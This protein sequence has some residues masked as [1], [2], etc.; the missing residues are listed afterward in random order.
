MKLNSYGD[1]E[2]LSIV[3]IYFVQ[4][5]RQQR[6]YNELATFPLLRRSLSVNAVLFAF[7]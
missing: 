6:V 4:S 5:I 3:A 1:V 2:R 7:H